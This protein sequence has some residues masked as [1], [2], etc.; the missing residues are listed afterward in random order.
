MLFILNQGEINFFHSVKSKSMYKYFCV[1]VLIF[2]LQIVG[3]SQNK[4]NVDNIAD[5]NGNISGSYSK[6]IEIVKGKSRD[7]SFLSLLGR[8]NTVSDSINLSIIDQNTL[9][10]AFKDRYGPCYEL[11][12]GKQK[13]KYFQFYTVKKRISIPIFYSNVNIHR[14][15]IKCL[16]NGNIEI[17]EYYNNSSNVFFMAAGGSSRTTYLLKK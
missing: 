1:F 11:Y 10:V 9:K 5:K 6:K 8:D 15:R 12:E 4:V 2:S 16:E 3:S 17:K 13:K 7:N 14:F